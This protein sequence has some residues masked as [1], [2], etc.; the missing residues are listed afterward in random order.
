[1]PYRYLGYILRDQKDFAGAIAAYREAIRVEPG[2]IGP[3]ID[4]GNLLVGQNDLDGAVAAYREA[5]QGDATSWIAWYN[6]GKILQK[7][8][9]TAGAVAAFQEAVKRGPT[10]PGVYNDLAMALCGQNTPLQG[11]QVLRDGAKLNP[12]WVTNTT[13]WLRYNLACC[14]LLGANSKGPEANVESSGELRRQALEWLSDDLS[15]WRGLWLGDPAKN[16][17]LISQR[18]DHWLKDP[19]LASVREIEK[20]PSDERPLWQKLWDDVRTLHTQTGQP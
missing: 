13:T 19:D 11:L 14:A 1:M 4:I 18:L 16:R 2:F 17:V 15:Y 3:I 9:D 6:L 5:T 10:I 12:S 20:L 7:K 8:K